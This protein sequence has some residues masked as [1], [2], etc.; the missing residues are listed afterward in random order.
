MP[1]HATQNI[2]VHP[3]PAANGIGECRRQDGK[4]LVALLLP[5]V[6]VHEFRKVPRL[7][8]VRN[9]CAEPFVQHR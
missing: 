5:A 2:H 1:N 4:L 6:D 8:L 7:Q 3:E 9:A